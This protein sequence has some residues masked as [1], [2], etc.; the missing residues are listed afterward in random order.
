MHKL[1]N[2]FKEFTVVL[3]RVQISS[4]GGCIFEDV[5]V[6][7]LLYSMSHSDFLKFIDKLPFFSVFDFP[8]ILNRY[9][10]A[11]DDLWKWE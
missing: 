6:L 1:G 4:V 9:C 3:E 10:W 5:F 2:C 8:E 7:C 11:L